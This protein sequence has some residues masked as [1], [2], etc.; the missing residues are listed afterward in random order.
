MKDFDVVQPGDLVNYG[1]HFFLFISYDEFE[2]S[3]TMFN[4]ATLE[5]L[6]LY[7][8]VRLAYV[9]YPFALSVEQK[10]CLI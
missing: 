9:V 3:T 2:N 4:V 1:T 7:F 5:I 6:K 10:K 8:V